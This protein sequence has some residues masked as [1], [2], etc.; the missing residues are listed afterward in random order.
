MHEHNAHHGVENDGFTGAY[1]FPN[2]FY[3]Y[4]W[5][6][7]LAGFTTIN[8]GATD[9]RAGAPNDAGGINKG[10]RDWRGNLRTYTVP[11]PTFRFPPPKASKRISALKKISSFPE[12]G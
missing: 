2:E 4:H 11:T 9:A 3:D 8:T 12:S 6:W 1:F 10:P 5:P 7:V